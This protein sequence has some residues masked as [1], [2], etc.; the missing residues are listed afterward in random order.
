MPTWIK[1]YT[2]FVKLTICQIDETRFLLD[3]SFMGF[4]IN[5]PGFYDMDYIVQIDKLNLK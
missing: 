2:P 5:F 1:Y 4:K 3:I